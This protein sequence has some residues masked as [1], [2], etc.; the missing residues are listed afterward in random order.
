[1]EDIRGAKKYRLFAAG[2][3]IIAGYLSLQGLSDNYFWDDEA[4]TALFSRNLLHFGHLTAWDGRNL[5]SRRDGIH[6]DRQWIN[7]FNSPLQFY[8]TAA[9]FRCLG[10]STQSARLPF[11]LLGLASLPIFYLILRLESGNDSR[12]S[13]I[14]LI[15]LSFSPSF[16]LFIRQCHY[17]SLT[18]F[19]SLF[20]YYFYRRSLYKFKLYYLMLASAG[21]IY[22]FFSHYLIGISFFFALVVRH[23]LLYRRCR[24]PLYYLTAAG[25]VG[26]ITFL[27][28]IFRGAVSPHLSPLSFSSWSS[29]KV[30][31]MGRYLQAI[32]DFGWFPGLMLLLAIGLY[33]LRRR[34]FKEPVWSWLLLIF[35]YLIPVTLLYPAR[36]S[37]RS[38]V[39]IRYLLPLLPFCCALSGVVVYNLAPVNRLAA[40][41]VL[42][43]LLFSNIFSLPFSST[44]P[45]RADL[46]GYVNEVHRDYTTAYEAAVDFIEK[47]CRQDEVVVVM[48]PNM[49]YPLQFYTGD[50]VIFGGRL[51]GKTPLNRARIRKLNPNFL[52]EEAR[53]DW[54]IS[55]KRRP[56]TDS[57]LQRY[58][59]VGL[60][61]YLFRILKVYYRGEALRPEVL[62]H[63]FGP[64]TEFDPRQDGILI[65]QRKKR[66]ADDSSPDQSSPPRS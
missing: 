18:L 50:R 7:R 9:S 64:V 14:G 43:L 60:E 53:P 2:I 27:L 8:L 48:P 3:I 22:L 15:I 38:L 63:R 29:E 6:L 45:P 34:W 31:I 42:L 11:V 19:F 62:A 37:A 66:D 26:V 33:W 17:Y 23:F 41:A 49:G 4:E 30:L 5:I 28:S 57:I 55:F 20:T 25:L 51:T 35:L 47:N 39:D 44:R 58:A 1:M 61:F 10:E 54:I 21:A 24:P 40:G 56:S 46:I 59:E 32:N 65:Y 36:Y 13:L 52:V 12:L 16:L